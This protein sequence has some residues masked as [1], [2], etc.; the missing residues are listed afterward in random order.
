MKVHKLNNIL[1]YILTDDELVKSSLIERQNYNLDQIINYLDK[2]GKVSTV[3]SKRQCEF[4]GK[5]AGSINYYTD[6]NWVWPEWLK[7][8]ISD[9]AINLPNIFIEKVKEDNIDENLIRRIVNQELEIEL[10]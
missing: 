4:C 5:I 7:H 10:S 8:Y 6:G 1:N 9:H 2:G 3:S